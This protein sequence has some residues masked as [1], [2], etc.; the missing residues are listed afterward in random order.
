MQSPRQE[1]ARRLQGA[2]GPVGWREVVRSGAEGDE[3]R[4][5]DT[6]S[7]RVRHAK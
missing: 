2:A 1:S 7:Y 4:L 6:W 5:W 3:V